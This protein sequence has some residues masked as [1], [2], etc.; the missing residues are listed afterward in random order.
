[1]PGLRK[2]TKILIVSGLTLLVS[3]FGGPVMSGAIFLLMPAD[4]PSVEHDLPPGYE[5]LHQGGIDIPTGLYVREDEDLVVGGTPPLILRRTYLSNYRVSTHFGIGATHNGEIYLHGDLRQISLIVAK[6]SRITFDRTSSGG[7]YLNAMFEHRSRDEWDGARLG[8]AGLGWA[9]RRA[10]GELALFQGCRQTTVCSIIQ[11][12]D[13]HGHTIMYR[14]DGSGRLA[15]M[16]ADDRWIAF[17]YD[18]RNRIIR[19]YS[20]GGPAVT[21]EYDPAGRLSRASGDDGVR[22]YTYTD[23]DQIETMEDPGRTIENQ[24]DANGRCIKQ[25]VRAAG[26]ADALTFD[27]SYRLRGHDVVQTDMTRSDGEWSTYTFSQNRSVLAERWRRPGVELHITYE[28]D[29][30]TEHATALT[31]TCPDRKGLPLRHTS[32]VTDGNEERVKTNL[33]PHCFWRPRRQER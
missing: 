6:G 26:E 27:F 19:A 14:R 23:R 24:Y 18:N 22:R 4:S 15:R 32:V 10:D 3:V 8:W 30:E 29:P 31:V 2:A 25:I 33:L 16:E 7:S 12:R 28:R 1:M 11:S 17:D 21:Y 20:S 13:I 5:P 9:L